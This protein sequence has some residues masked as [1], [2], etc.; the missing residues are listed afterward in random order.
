E[1]DMKS[2][3]ERLTATMK[4]DKVSLGIDPKINDEPPASPEDPNLFDSQP[5]PDEDQGDDEGDDDEGATV[6]EFTGP[7]FSAGDE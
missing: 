1:Q 2:E 5:A 4:V 6:H 3:G 7:S